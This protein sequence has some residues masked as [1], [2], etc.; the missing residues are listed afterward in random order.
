MTY[1]DNV[2]QLDNLCR[3][4]RMNKISIDV[5]LCRDCM[6]K[7]I[8][9]ESGI[10]RDRKSLGTR[11]W[12]WYNRHMMHTTMLTVAI[13]FGATIPHIIWLDYMAINGV[14][15]FQK[16]LEIDA[17]MVAVEHIEVIPLAKIIFDSV[18][19]LRRKYRKR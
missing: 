10:K 2:D 8:D 4:C 15:I 3:L 12:N 18:I 5:E 9:I 14:I 13:A 17:F 7:E 16:H 19:I 11:F 6:I 1:L